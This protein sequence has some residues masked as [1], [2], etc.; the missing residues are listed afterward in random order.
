[1]TN[2]Y[3]GPKVRCLTTKET[4]STLETW[5]QTVIYGLRLNADFR[6]Y[7]NEGARFGK[8]SKARPYR[9]LND[10][11][12]VEKVTVNEVEQELVTVVKSE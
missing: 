3:H 10:D 4:L 5:R 8:K 6:P 11:V 7:L 1:M 2:L 9:E 12:K